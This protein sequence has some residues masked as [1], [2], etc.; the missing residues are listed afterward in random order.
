MK[1]KD[2]TINVIRKHSYII[3][4]LSLSMIYCQEILSDPFAN[5]Y[6]CKEN[7]LSVNNKNCFNNILVFDQKKYQVNSFAKNKNGDIL[8]QFSEQVK[9]DEHSFSRLFY[10]L[11]KEGKY[12]FSNKTSYSNEVNVDNDEEKFYNNT[13]YSLDSIINSKSLFVS[14]LNAPNKENQYLFSINSF[15]S[16]VELYDLNNDNNNYYIWSFQKFFNLDPD[17]YLFPFDYELFEIKEKNEYIIV[18]IPQINIYDGILDVSFMKRFRFQSFDEN[19]Y[20]E[21][22]SITYQDYLDSNILKVFLLDDLNILFVLSGKEYCSG[23]INRRN[24]FLSM[25]SDNTEKRKLSFCCETSFELNLTF[26]N[27]NLKH[28]SYIK[29]KEFSLYNRII[30]DEKLFMK[31][32]PLNILEEKVIIIIY[33]YNLL[34]LFLFI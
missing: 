22:D 2:L 15:N 24:E 14:I 5:I 1:T 12:F 32:L 27:V 20:E 8:I 4:F 26:Y 31:S 3:L 28:F 23:Y 11:T 18:F 21:R 7:E 17:D 13:F 9:Y 29:D 34:F 30:S 6:S 10:G 19:A 33:Y 16:M 25:V